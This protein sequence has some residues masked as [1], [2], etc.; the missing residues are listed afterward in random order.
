MST[1]KSAA[2]MATLALLTS[3][4]APGSNQDDALRELRFTTYEAPPW[5][6]PETCWGKDVTPAVVE[7]VTEQITVRPAE[8]DTDGTVLRPASY[9]TETRQ[10]ILRE[11]REEWFESPC[12]ATQDPDFIAS[13][14]R[15][16]AARSLYDRPVT[17]QMDRATQEA[18]RR[19][20]ATD[21]PNSGIL[22]LASARRLGLVALDR[23]TLDD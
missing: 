4:A 5:A 12:A 9:R 2:I 14:Q 23:A 15:A 22:S 10:A 1:R 3:C 19:Y 17:G 18:V 16:L 8:I 7:T 13:L 21:G 11:R 6:P 20:Q